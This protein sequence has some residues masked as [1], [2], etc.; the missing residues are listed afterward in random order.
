VVFTLPIA[1]YLPVMTALAWRLYLAQDAP[2][3]EPG[4]NRLAL[5]LVDAFSVGAL[6]CGLGLAFYLAAQ[7]RAPSDGGQATPTRATLLVWAVSLVAAIA[8]G[9]QAFTLSH[10]LTGGG[11][12]LT[13]RTWMLHVFQEGFQRMAFGPA[14]ASSSMLLIP[15]LLL[16]TLTGLG[17][18]LGGIYIDHAPAIPAEAPPRRG[19]RYV[20]LILGLLGGL[21]LCVLSALPLVSLLGAG[22]DPEAMAQTE[23]LFPTG[24][25]LA[26]TLLP[27]AG[28]VFL[29]IMPVTYLGALG[30]G[31]LRPLG[32]RS[33]LLLL[34][35]SPWLLVGTGPLAIAFFQ[36]VRVAGLLGTFPALVPPVALS[37]PILFILTLFFRGRFAHWQTRRAE[38]NGDTSAFLQAVIAPSLPLALLLGLGAVFAG[39]GELLWP[40]LM[41][42]RPDT[43]PVSV[44]L[45]QIGGQA[46]GEPAVAG[47]L[48]RLGLPLVLGF[49]VLFVL[50]QV[51][52]LDRL[53][54]A[55]WRED[56]SA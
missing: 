11:P 16:S 32:R 56:G 22:L 6:A 43:F 17:I 12:A 10:L 48:V 2:L 45:A 40:L 54:I 46:P 21:G 41:S 49:F 50:A 33:E 3:R 23:G 8:S 39:A 15:L 47:A 42:V 44:A 25:T 36:R 24:R 51:L 13:T 4:L 27:L 7:R 34:P 9:L 31:A 26:N 1:L 38:G 35:F 14:A 29:V 5:L 37:V 53:R 19:L 30:I 18:I 52:Y 55:H 28:A 20:L